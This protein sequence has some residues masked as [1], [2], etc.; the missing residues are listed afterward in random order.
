[1][2]AREL[3]G[4]QLRIEEDLGELIRSAAQIKE[5]LRESSEVS[6]QAHQ[7]ELDCA[8][9]ESDIKIRAKIFNHTV[10]RQAHL[11]AALSRIANG[12]FGRCLVCEEA[13]TLRR[14]NAY[15]SAILC[16]DCQEC[17]EGG[18]HPEPK[19]RPFA[20]RWLGREIP[21]SKK[22]A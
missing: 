5:E 16:F 12:T 8:K 7:D 10:N 3:S 11:R 15:P 20:P 17:K 1:M 22:A 9:G 6:S 13:I 21:D 14:M 2:N 18:I 4:F 19:Q